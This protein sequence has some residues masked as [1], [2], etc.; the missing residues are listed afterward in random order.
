M[1]V[2]K[3]VFTTLLTAAFV[4]AALTYLAKMVIS[5]FFQKSMDVELARA[6]AAIEDEYKTKQ[7]TLE[8]EQGEK[9]A[10]IKEQ[11]DRRMEN[12]KAYLARAER[13]EA[14]RL[15]RRGES[16][17]SIWELTGAVNLF[18]QS[19]E[20]NQVA[21][22][23]K[24]RDWYFKQGWLLSESA[25]NHYFLVQETLNFA[26]LRSLELKRPIDDKLYAS[27][28]PPVEVLKQ[29]RR[30]TLRLPE[31]PR[32]VSPTLEDIRAAVVDWKKNSGDANGF[33]AQERA[34]VIF[35]FV[36]S[37]FRTRLTDELGSRQT[38]QTQT[39]ALTIVE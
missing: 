34:W 6:K 22:S 32:E 4:V 29:I 7:N 24:L 9:L 23:K 18:G 26:I 27:E 13:L 2:V 17:G 39:S 12:L 33:T 31:N 30:E 1:T 14:E 3:E 5:G 35:Q 36:L 20:V 16:Y 8:R 10:A 15:R 21:L 19:D 37:S 28:K 25:K 38:I 11:A